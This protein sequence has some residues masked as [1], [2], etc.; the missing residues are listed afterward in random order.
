MTHIFQVPIAEFALPFNRIWKRV[1][2]HFGIA[3]FFGF[4]WMPVYNYGL[5]HALKLVF[6]LFISD[7]SQAFVHII[8]YRKLSAKYD[9]I[10]HTRERVIYTIVFHL[11]AMY[12]MFFLTLTPGIHFLFGPSY[13]DAF[14][15]LLRIWVL[16]LVLTAIS[17][18]LVVCIE[19]FNNWKKSFATEEQLNAQMM[20]YKY[21][22]LR[23]QVNPHFLLDSFGTLKALVRSEPQRAVDFIQKMS[24]LY[25]NVLDVKDQEFIPLHDE[26]RYLS[27]YIDL[28]K[29]RYNGELSFQIDINAEHDDLIIPLALQSLLEYAVEYFSHHVNGMESISL[30]KRGD[31]IELKGSKYIGSRIAGIGSP[32]LRILEQQYQFYSK[33]PLMYEENSHTFSIFIPLLKQ[34]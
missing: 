7:L 31:Q 26:L 28:L 2:M 33:R 9:W 24:D 12:L 15:T 21:E 34:A 4:L 6:M 29:I 1:L 13:M 27:N 32:G 22:A 16:P 23:N 18:T 30:T 11:T 5:F 19:F 20:N 3:V 10:E 25:R 8:I 17:M 14:Q